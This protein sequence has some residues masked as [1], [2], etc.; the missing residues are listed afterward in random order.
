[1]CVVRGREWMIELVVYTL[2][3][4][5]L[6]LRVATHYLDAVLQY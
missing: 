2:Y 5:T 1:M 6:G 4:P 3:I